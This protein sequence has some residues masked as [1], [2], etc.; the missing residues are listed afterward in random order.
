MKTITVHVQA[1]EGFDARGIA[2]LVQEASRFESSIHLTDGSRRMNAKSLMGMMALG[3]TE[4]D[5]VY[6]EASGNDEEE[7]VSVLVEFLEGR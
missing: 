3:I 4:G 6:I 5:D 1:N 7:A 2:L